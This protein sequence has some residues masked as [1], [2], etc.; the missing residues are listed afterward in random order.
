MIESLAARNPQV[1]GIKLSRNRGHQAALLAGLLTVPGD[2]VISV[3]AD[4]Q[5]DLAAISEMVDAHE[6]GIQIVYGVR[7]SRQSDS[8]FKRWTAELYYKVLAR[9]GVEIVFNHADYRL[10]SRRALDALAKYGEANIFLRG[11]VPQLGF[12]SSTVLYDRH[13]RFAGESKYPLR[14]ML[15]L[16]WNSVTSFSA[17]PLRFITALGFLVSL[18]SLSITAWAIYTRLFRDTAVPGWASTVLPIYFLGGIQLLSIGMI[19]EYVA[20]IYLESKRRPRFEIERILE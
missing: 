2:A 8:R 3:D 20:K 17:A 5:D 19:G 13:E 9:L 12:A 16:A 14:K 11:L 10:L 4:L 7:R 6:S 18:G 15:A 1:K